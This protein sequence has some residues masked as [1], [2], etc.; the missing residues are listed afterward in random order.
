MAEGSTSSRAWW[1]TDHGVTVQ[2]VVVGDCALTDGVRALLAAGREATVNAAKWSGGARGVDLLRGGAGVGDRSSCGTGLGGSTP[3]AW[4][5]TAGHRRVH[6]GPHGPARGTAVIRQLPDR[7]PR[8]S[9][10]CPQGRGV[11]R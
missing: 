6:P 11:R 4:P 5:T 9:W 8:S 2:V 3:T 1:R 10:S 7:G